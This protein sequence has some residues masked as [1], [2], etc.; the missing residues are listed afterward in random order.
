[1]NTPAEK[2]LATKSRRLMDCRVIA[3]FRGY[4]NSWRTP[5]Q[6]ASAAESR[7]K[8]FNEFIRDHRSQDD[9]R[10]EVERIYEDRCDVCGCAWEVDRSEAVPFCAGCG[11]EVDE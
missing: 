9:I 11:T 4:D 10:L 8:E 5:E 6:N 7:C 3:E 2:T 1:M